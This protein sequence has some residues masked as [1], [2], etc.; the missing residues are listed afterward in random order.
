MFPIYAW[1]EQRHKFLPKLASGEWLSKRPD[2]PT[3]RTRR[4]RNIGTWA[5]I[6][7]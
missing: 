4:R 6:T 5:T 3:A 1:L 2:E 7:C